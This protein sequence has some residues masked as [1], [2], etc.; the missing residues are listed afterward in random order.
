MLSCHVTELSYLYVYLYLY[1]YILRTIIL[2]S[3][4]R[5]DQYINGGLLQ[6][7]LMGH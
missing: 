2:N 7:K 1:L 4:H 5:I 6:W 3:G